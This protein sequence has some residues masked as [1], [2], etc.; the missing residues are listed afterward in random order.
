MCA[1]SFSFTFSFYCYLVSS[2]VAMSGIS[3]SVRTQ[4]ECKWYW[5]SGRKYNIYI[6][7]NIQARVEIKISPPNLSDGGSLHSPI[8]AYFN[9]IH[10]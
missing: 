2:A 5:L 1:L 10:I 9:Y 3:V 8:R 7:T 6:V 4:C